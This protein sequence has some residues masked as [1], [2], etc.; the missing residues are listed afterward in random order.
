MFQQAPAFL[1][2]CIIAG[3]SARWVPA[4][5][6]DMYRRI[7]K[8]IIW[9]PLPAIT[10]EK[11]SQLQLQSEMIFPIGSAWLVFIVSAMFFGI[12][13]KIFRWDLATWAVLTMVCG[14]GNTSF[15]GF[16]VVK[17]VFGEEAVRYAIFVD[18]PGS[19]LCLST[20]GIT[21]AAI[22]GSGKIS[23]GLITKRLFLFPPF[24][25][26]LLSLMLP[27]EWFQHS[28]ANFSILDILHW[29]GTWMTPL[30]F[31]SLGMQFQPSF[32]GIDF[33]P[34]AAGLS[35]KLIL[36]PLLVSS[37]F[38]LANKSGTMYDVSILE[39][40]MPPMIT[41]SIIATDA[42]LQPKLANGLINFGIPVSIFTLWC[43]ISFLT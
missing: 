13:S 20:L 22:A 19:F 11:I 6:E 42:G 18:Q 16:P 40:A 27:A 38:A 5:P 24:P 28:I 8:F 29:I 36:A 4:I 35:Y 39:I 15:I 14:L 31:I 3:L 41:A 43:W 23:L 17:Y 2:L 21:V 12:L 26:F 7:N 9:L 1:I 25:C 10:L 32:K 37:I 34:F 30:A 33:P